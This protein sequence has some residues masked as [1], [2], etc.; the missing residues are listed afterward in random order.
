LIATTFLV[1]LEAAQVF[2]FSR[3]T[4]GTALVV[5]G[6]AAA[7]A[8]MAAGVAGGRPVATVRAEGR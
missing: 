8:A 3:T 1:G 7:A 6:A 5:A 4:D 2:V